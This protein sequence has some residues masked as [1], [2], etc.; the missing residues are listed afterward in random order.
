LFLL[1]HMTSNHWLASW[2]T[3]SLYIA[4]LW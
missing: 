1:L 4:A 3:N 2:P